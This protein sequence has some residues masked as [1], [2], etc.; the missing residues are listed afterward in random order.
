MRQNWIVRFWQSFSTIGLL[1]GTLFFAA[2]LTPTLLP[3]VA[4][5]NFVPLTGLS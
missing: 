4:T 1:L 3:R 2:S 5:C